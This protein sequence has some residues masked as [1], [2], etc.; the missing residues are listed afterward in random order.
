MKVYIYRLP[1]NIYSASDVQYVCI[2]PAM[3]RYDKCC[4]A[5]LCKVY[6][7][8]NNIYTLISFNDD[9]HN[10]NKDLDKIISYPK[11]RTVVDKDKSAKLNV[12]CV[13]D[14]YSAIFF[15]TTVTIHTIMFLIQ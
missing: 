6:I 4:N 9:R 11:G 8:N 14:I 10:M 15:A 1:S 2:A 5:S 12:T 7:F 3:S 13:L